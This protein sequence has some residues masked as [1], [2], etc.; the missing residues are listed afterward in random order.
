MSEVFLSSLG[1]DVVV[2]SHQPLKANAWGIR[3][4]STVA[5]LLFAR[6]VS[7]PRGTTPHSRAENT[8]GWFNTGA[9]I[10]LFS[11]C[12]PRTPNVCEATSFAARAEEYAVEI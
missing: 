3:A 8:V 9:D 4:R 5:S 10:Q 1:F 7:V 2:A 11:E 12:R 6:L